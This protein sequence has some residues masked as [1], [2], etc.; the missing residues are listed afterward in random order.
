MD[1]ELK[2]L[3]NLFEDRDEVVTEA[4]NKRI[5]DKGPDVLGSIKYLA[6]QSEDISKRNVIYS[7]LEFFRAVFRLSDI[8]L[9][10]HD[11]QDRCTNLFEG[12][13]LI[14]ALLDSNFSSRK[15]EYTFNQMLSTFYFDFDSQS[16]MKK[17]TAIENIEIFNY[18]FFDINKMSICDALMSDE[19]SGLLNYV[20]S[21]SRRRGN[22]IAVATVYLILAN[23]LGLNF[24][25]MCFP[26]GFVPAYIE[27]GNIL[28]YV[29]IFNDGTIFF[30]SQLLNILEQQGV[31]IRDRSDFKL[32]ELD[33]LY[34][35]YLESM[36]YIYSNMNVSSKSLMIERA[37]NCFGSER[38]LTIDMDEDE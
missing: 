23:E 26:G 1:T 33:A 34:T 36:L 11:E 15:F 31:E 32:C 10:S 5:L 24:K 3:V 13:A 30:E 22:P 29:N 12:F 2:Y 14:A 18:L 9:F 37:L 7:R 25:L 27:D 16:R 19:K 6:R 35:I 8:E 28:F 38:Y 17:K 20:I 21:D 4:V